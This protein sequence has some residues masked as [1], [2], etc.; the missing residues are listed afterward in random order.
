[1]KP[2]NSIK[3]QGFRF[4][5]VLQLKKNTFIFFKKYQKIFI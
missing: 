3:I 1:M 2:F 5:M 4:K